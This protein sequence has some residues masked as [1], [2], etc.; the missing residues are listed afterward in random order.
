MITGH[1]A[2]QKGDFNMSKFDDMICGLQ[3][4]TEVPKD[5]WAKYT[6]ALS[7]LP[8]K[9]E[10]RRVSKSHWMK[11]AASAAAVV[12]VGSVVCYSNPAL[13]AKIPFIGNIFK[14][15]QKISTFSGEYDEK[16]K[17]LSS[18]DEGIS[19]SIYTAEAS[20][21]TITASEVYCDGLSIFLTAEVDVEKGGLES[22]PGGLIY[23]DGSWKLAG[24]TEERM[25]IN[26][27]LEGKAID[28]HTFI[29]ML[30]LD[31]DETDLQGST[32]E[33]KLSM[34][35][36]D[37]VNELDAEDISASHKIQ[38]E[39]D[40]SIPFTVDRE[41]VRTIEIRKENKGY[42]LDKVFVSPYQ[43]ITYTDVPYV[44][45]EITRDEY[46]K[47]MEEKTG[48]SG[49]DVGISY[50]EYV[51][52]MG[53]TY[54]QCSTL[55]FNQ[56]GV[57]LQPTEEIRGRSVNA[58]QDMEISKLYIYVFDDF[59]DWIE[60]SENGMDSDAAERAVIAEEVD[61]K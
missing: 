40:L 10:E 61:V 12:M 58:V 31:L 46:E 35:G 41:A 18:D 11:Y 51:E 26:S 2:W 28:D 39:W 60:M 14:E 21:V 1:F 49:E 44:E 34:I 54:A 7:K 52:Q 45:Q 3:Q 6:D 33:L 13:A 27:N 36:Y 56:D 55:I 15:V 17:V 32:M 4:D 25:L 20:G 8:D 22:I 53:K 48:G 24:D 38:A 5:V 59:D 37:D 16:A 23:L 42:C 47:A 30:K 19:D 9:Q 43:V 29:G 50:E 57:Q